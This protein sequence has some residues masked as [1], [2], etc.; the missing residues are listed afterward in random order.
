MRSLLQNVDSSVED[1]NFSVWSQVCTSAMF[2]KCTSS[3]RCFQSLMRVAQSIGD[4]AALLVL[5]PMVGLVVGWLCCS[6]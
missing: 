1:A 3:S 5:V 2:H 4:L 6:A